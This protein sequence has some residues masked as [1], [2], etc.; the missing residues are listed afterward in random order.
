MR[1]VG[2]TR[3]P[4]RLVWV[5][6]TSS[7]SRS[8]SPRQ[9]CTRLASPDTYARRPVPALGSS[10][11]AAASLTAS[12]ASHV[13]AVAGRAPAPRCCPSASSST[14]MTIRATWAVADSHR[15]D[16]GQRGFVA[17]QHH[18]VRVR[19]E[20]KLA[21]RSD[22]TDGVARPKPVRPVFRRRISACACRQ[23]AWRR[24]MSRPPAR[25]ISSVKSWAGTDSI[26]SSPAADIAS[27]SIRGAIYTISTI[28]R[29]P[30]R[31]T[32]RFG[33]ASAHRR[34]PLPA[35]WARSAPGPEG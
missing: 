27:R 23:S 5:A 19:V 32:A 34:D 13:H 30:T 10:T 26:A 1:G 16:T 12:Q 22:C 21:A 25:A 15:A 11:A 14:S 8:S 18:P 17:D 33:Q 28:V 29:S 2:A 4:I 24:R 9:A 7:P 3:A 31:R 35:G 6:D 20:D